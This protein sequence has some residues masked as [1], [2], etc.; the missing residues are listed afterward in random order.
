M[1]HYQKIGQAG[2]EIASFFL[3]KK[4]FKIIDRHVTSRWGEID[5]VAKK[6]DN[7]IFFI[8]VKTRIGEKKGKP[9]EAITFYKIKKLKRAIQYYLLKNNLNNYKLS[10][11]V[12][13]IILDSNLNIKELKFFDSVEI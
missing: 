9:Y 3:K 12:I 10:L 1:L 6:N 7:K 13:S 4:G 11:G 2:E 8:E 5:I